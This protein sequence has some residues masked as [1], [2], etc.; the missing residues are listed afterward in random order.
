[1][2]RSHNDKQILFGLLTLTIIGA[3]IGASLQKFE[4]VVL[5]NQN[6]ASVIESM[7]THT[8]PEVP[9]ITLGFVGDIMLDRGVAYS[10]NKNF[11]GDYTKIFEKADFLKEPDIMFANLEGPIS[12]K[13]T[14]AGSIYSFRM[15]PAVVPALKDSGID[16]V[17]FANNHVGDYARPAFEDTITRMRSIGILTCGAGMNKLEAET[18]AIFDVQGF[19]VGFLCFSDVGPSFMEATDTDSGILLANDPAFD[20]II[21]NA[22]QEVNT[23]VVSFH[24]GEE[25]QTVHND[26]QEALAHRAIDNGA[27]MIVGHHPHVIQDVSSYNGVSIIYSLGNFIF[28]QPFSDETMEGMYAKATIHGGITL[29]EPTEIVSISKQF[30]PSLKK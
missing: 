19:R 25:Y 20:T 3:G 23:L 4:P 11:K 24:W 18:P 28:D 14:Q 21:K 30:I 17:S 27:D 1:M 26:R 2:K 29:E 13:G 12:D 9:K 15:D 5:K 7:P 16:V 6:L 10:V 22:K 8:T